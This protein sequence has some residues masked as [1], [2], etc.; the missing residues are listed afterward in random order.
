MM[1]PAGSGA[2]ACISV[3]PDAGICAVASRFLKAIQWQGMFM[4]ELLL[5]TEGRS[6]F[7]ELNGR[8][9][10]SMALARKMGFE[11][12]AWT[13]QSSLDPEFVPSEPKEKPPIVCRHLG[14]ELL[15]L[16]FVCRGA[17][18]GC[19]AEWPGKVE[20]AR[21]VL[22]FDRSDAWY[23]DNRSDSKVFW[24]ETWQTLMS[25]LVQVTRRW[26]PLRIPQR[27][28][29]RIKR[30]FVRRSQ[31]L[32]RA[33]GDLLD[34]LNPSTRILFLCYG[35]IN[36]SALAEQYL[37]QLGGTAAKVDSC[38]FHLQESRPIDPVMRRIA[39]EFGIRFS[40]WSS[41]HITRQLV[42]GAD[43]IFA[44]EAQH[45]VRLFSEYP[46]ARGRA[47]L[48]SCVTGPETIPLE[49]EDPFGKPADSYRRCVKEVMFAIE[50]ISKKL[51]TTERP[52][53]LQVDVH[54]T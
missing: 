38:G 44:M 50:P 18:T 12:P 35:N 3:K 53:D 40:A 8:A 43:L 21:R 33:K 52:T 31:E 41:R 36:R 39:A 28:L 7:I 42:A 23:N 11:Y 19:A 26:K 32:I 54:L 27:I 47:F 30:P 45:L 20:T 24:A 37:R 51:M 14:R 49:I 15:H 5:D 6:W 29:N 34:R 25:P 17:P 2:I 48:L 46:E 22:R 10:G 13:V 16:A 4:I 9:W 1:N